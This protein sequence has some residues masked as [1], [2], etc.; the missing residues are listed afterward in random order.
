MSLSISEQRDAIER[1]EDSIFE[2]RSNG[3]EYNFDELESSKGFEYQRDEF[4]MENGGTPYEVSASQI[5]VR[6][7]LTELLDVEDKEEVDPIINWIR[8]T[9]IQNA[10]DISGESIHEALNN[11]DFIRNTAI[12]SI[13]NEDVVRD[14]ARQEAFRTTTSMANEF[15]P[16]TEDVETRAS[17]AAE[18]T[19]K[20]TVK[21]ILS[22]KSKI[23]NE[24]AIP[25]YLE[26]YF[27]LKYTTIEEHI[28]SIHQLLTFHKD[29]VE[30][31]KEWEKTESIGASLLGIGVISGVLLGLSQSISLN[32][33]H[34]VF[35]AVLFLS[36]VGLLLSGLLG[37]RKARSNE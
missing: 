30:G 9:T 36:G 18:T 32:T 34:G 33:V 37:L 4:Y 23:D 2:E 15:V 1:E 5:D 8:S 12:P 10:V 35:L 21:E 24:T 14:V 20:E 26:A 13:V 3:E 11:E 19:T 25:D 27:D 28:D 6:E 16:R 31:K 22:D 7:Y 17:L 29:S